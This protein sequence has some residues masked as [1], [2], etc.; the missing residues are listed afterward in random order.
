[1]TSLVPL[2]GAQEGSFGGVRYQISG[3]RGTLLQ[4]ELAQTLVDFDSKALLARGDGVWVLSRVGGF[5]QRLFSGESRLLAKGP[6]QITLRA[7]GRVVPLHIPRGQRIEA[8]SH[9]ALAY[10]ETIARSSPLFSGGRDSFYASQD[11]VLW[12]FGY[13]DIFEARLA[14]GEHLEVE[15]GSWL[16]RESGVWVQ[17]VYEPQGLFGRRELLR[18]VGPGRVGLH[19]PPP[20]PEIYWHNTSIHLHRHRGPR[21]DSPRREPRM[22]FPKKQPW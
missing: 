22:G 16:Y 18:F 17:T 9:Q 2:S 4:L 5:W 10:T 8:R 7:E 21:R 6:G 15:S 13:G 3:E 11:G 12:L 14:P 19:N 20:E 1:M